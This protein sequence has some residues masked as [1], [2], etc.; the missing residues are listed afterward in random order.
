MKKYEKMELRI[1]PF[2]AKEDLSSA[3]LSGWLESEGAEFSDARITT[4][5]VES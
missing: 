5:E 1:V 3:G 4:Y 2:T